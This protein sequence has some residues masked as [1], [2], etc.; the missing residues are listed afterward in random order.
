[1]ENFKRG[2]HCPNKRGDVRGVLRNYFCDIATL[3]ESKIE[4][5]NHPTAI[6]L[7][8]HRLGRLDILA[9]YRSIWGII[10]I[11]DKSSLGVG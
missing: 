8:G 5:V 4:D 6:S 11:W 3:Q 2:L 10:V 7:W 1:M 9:I